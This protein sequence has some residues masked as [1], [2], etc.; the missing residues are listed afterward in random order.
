MRRK[1]SVFAGP[2]PSAETCQGNRFL[3]LFLSSD[4]AIFEEKNKL[5]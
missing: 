5:K 2:E 3:T 1:E 4:I